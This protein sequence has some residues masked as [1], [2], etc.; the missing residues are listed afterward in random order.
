MYTLTKE[1]SQNVFNRPYLSRNLK[2]QNS[3]FK[4]TEST[5]ETESTKGMGILEPFSPYVHSLN[6]INTSTLSGKISIFLPN[7]I[8]TSNDR[9][10][11]EYITVVPG[12]TWISQ[13][14][15]PYNPDPT[16]TRSN[17]QNKI[18]LCLHLIDP[19]VLYLQVLYDS[20]TSY[21][22][23]EQFYA[24]QIEF[25]VENLI[26][27]PEPWFFF[28]FLTNTDPQTSRGTVATVQP[29]NNG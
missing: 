8:T 11:S 1:S 23:A 22:E 5:H 13:L 9:R 29:S 28:F 24:Y 27:A 15:E 6:H 19:R 12:P 25:T 7:Q 4:L 14:E 18:G 26:M 20:A 2:M 17:Y 10:L 3:P 16:A 21:Q